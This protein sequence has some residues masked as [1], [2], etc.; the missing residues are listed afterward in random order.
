MSRT[1]DSNT[2]QAAGF[3]ALLCLLFI[4]LKLTKF[5][6]WTWT[7]VLS[8]IWLPFALFFGVL[9]FFGTLA[10]LNAFVRSIFQQISRLCP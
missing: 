3:P 6:D 1:S 4:G 9:A 2:G 10:L 7:W 5:I 8:P